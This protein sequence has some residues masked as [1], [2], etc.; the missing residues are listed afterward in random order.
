MINKCSSFHCFKN[1]NPAASMTSQKWLFFFL[2]RR[3]LN[4]FYKYVVLHGSK[5]RIQCPQRIF[6][7]CV[8]VCVCVLPYAKLP[9]C[10]RMCMCMFSLCMRLANEFGTEMKNTQTGLIR[11]RIRIRIRIYAYAISEKYAA[12]TVFKK[13]NFFFFL[14][15]SFCVTL[16]D[17]E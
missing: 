6:H 16:F 11:I 4:L 5:Q 3:I 13:K 9:V 15:T 1:F 17:V 12:G 10:A 2:K 14:N 8:C 7:V